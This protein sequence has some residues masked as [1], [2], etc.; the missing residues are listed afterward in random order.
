MP[1][2][3]RTCAPVPDG[4]G[5]HAA[6]TRRRQLGRLVGLINST[7]ELICTAAMINTSYL[8]TAAHCVY[9]PVTKF[10]L[11]GAITYAAG[12]EDATVTPY[13]VVTAAQV[14]A[15]RVHG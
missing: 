14:Q 7:E 13:G 3:R 4:G 12:Q 9:L 11:A 5:R 8:L 1:R 15:D 2:P 6:R 10:I